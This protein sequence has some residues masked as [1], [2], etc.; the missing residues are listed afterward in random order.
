MKIRYP[1][2][3]TPFRSPSISAKKKYFLTGN[4]HGIYFFPHDVKSWFA[5]C[6]ECVW[7]ALIPFHLMM[8]TA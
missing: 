4:I 2:F 6:L 8:K 5:N 1:K 7:K 3:I